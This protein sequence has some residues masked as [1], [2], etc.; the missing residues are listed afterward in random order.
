MNQHYNAVD[1]LLHSTIIPGDSLE[2]VVAMLEANTEA[3]LALA[4]EQRTANLIAYAT[5]IDDTDTAAF[6]Q[7]K[8]RLERPEPPK[9]APVEH[10]R[11]GPA[12]CNCGFDAYQINGIMIDYS[13][14][15]AI[16]LRRNR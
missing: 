14:E 5:S 7:I 1:T 9:P 4:Y 11:V 13:E 2:G 8:E 6:A 10:Y 3:T 16:H 12:K 15:F